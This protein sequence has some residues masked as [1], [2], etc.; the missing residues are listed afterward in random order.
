[1]RVIN[2]PKRAKPSYSRDSSDPLDFHGYEL[3]DAA[4]EL[5]EATGLGLKQS[6]LR[7]AAIAW[8]DLLELRNGLVVC[9]NGKAVYVKIV[10]EYPAV[11]QY[12]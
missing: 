5:R 4:H 11:R 9:V 7:L 12:M 6:M 10:A 1:M 8:L 2:I 3:E